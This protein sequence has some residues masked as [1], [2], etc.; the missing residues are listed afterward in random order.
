MRLNVTLAAAVAAIIPVLAHAADTPAPPPLVPITSFVKADQYYNPLMSP[1]GKHLA[2]TVRT[3]VGQRTIPMVT[4]YSLPD[5]K[6]E[7]T[8]R[9]PLFSVPIG[10]RWVSNTRLIVQ[11]GIEVGTREKPQSTGEILAMDFD[12]SHQDY[13]FGYDMA[14]YSSRSSRY[15]ADQGYAYPLYLPREHNDHVLLR[16]YQWDLD[17]S[18]VYDVDTRSAIRK[19]V[20]TVNA[21]NASFAVQ[22]DGKPR[23]AIGSTADGLH[24]V[25]RLNDQ[26]GQWDVVEGNKLDYRLTPFA[27][28]EDDSKVFAWSSESGG[29]TKLLSQDMATGARKTLAEDP[30]GDISTVM[31]GGRRAL[32]I[33]VLTSSGRPRTVYLEDSNPNVL[34]HKDLSR[35]F[36]DSTVQFLSETDDGGKVLFSVR[37]DR[38]PGAYFIYD[39][40]TNKADMLFAA[41]AEIEPEDMALRRPINF[42]ARDGL[43]IDGYLTLPVQKTAQKPPLIL[44]PHG[45]PASSDE[46]YFDADA[47]FLA[48][49]GYAVLQLN[50]RD[51]N[52][53][54]IVFENR[55]HRQWGG[56]VMDDLVDGVKWAV[57]QGEVDGSRMCVFGASF[58]GYSALMLA[59]REPSMFKCAV[60]Y[61]GVYDLAL[62]QKEDD[63][64]SNSR[65]RATYKRYFGEDPAEWTRYSP[66]QHADAI[67]A[68]VLLIHGGKD[69]RAP[70]EQ[71]F[72]MKEA[73]EKAGH[74]PEWYYVDYEGHGFYD[75]ANQTEVYQRL[76]NFFAKYL[77]KPR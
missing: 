71:A 9:M 24:R 20:T 8:V 35:Q 23:F 6:L 68:G 28:S 36:A 10:Y 37:S 59:A 13:L 74:P 31:L 58:G 62:M 30:L 21:P 15:G 46:W 72:L 2:V 32:P 63:L 57:Q 12:G 34:L 49:R 38:D 18:A 55:S 11:K 19:L 1:D 64:V 29:P 40:K 25:W 61:A 47:Q 22:N 65:K 45:G 7:S 70:K 4:F 69:K 67:K 14:K 27:F 42:K 54:G 66:T 41:G 5:L 16:T 43:R 50:F 60:G 44:V 33:A 51:S 53:K 39:R 77:G 76:E 17:Q 3:P 73:L 75:T 48:N 52:G 56:K 26:T